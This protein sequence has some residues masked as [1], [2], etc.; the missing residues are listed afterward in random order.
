MCA[1]AWPR[2]NVIKFLD[3]LR[4][5]S[6]VE[7][8]RLRKDMRT[9]SPSIQGPWNP[10]ITQPTDWNV[11]TFPEAEGLKSLK[12]TK[13][14]TEIVLEMARAQGILNIVHQ[15]DKEDGSEA[16]SSSGPRSLEREDDQKIH[17]VTAPILKS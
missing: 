11:K 13:T 1:T 10:F 7:I 2:E 8:M 12:Y 16:D 15:K 14:A 6:G 4:C 17:P 5:R 9:E 3:Q